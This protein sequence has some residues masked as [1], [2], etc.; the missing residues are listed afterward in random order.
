MKRR[1][2]RV[3]C[4]TAI[5]FLAVPITIVASGSV[6]SGPVQEEEEDYY[7]KWLSEDALYIIQPD[8]RDVFENLT[9]QEEKA[10]FIEQ[11]WY[12]RDP[13]S[14]TSINEFKEEHYRLIA[15]ANQWFK[16]GKPGWRTDRGRIYIMH[17]PP[18]ETESHPAGGQYQR[19]TYQGGGFTSQGFRMGLPVHL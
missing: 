5:L 1:C 18:D 8:E 4:F 7:R 6:Q 3:F 2:Y 19:P 16:S 14:R 17:G 13:D 12:R 9:T 15:Y 11:F 10:R